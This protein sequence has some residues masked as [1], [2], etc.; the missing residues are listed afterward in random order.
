MWRRKV[1]LWIYL[2]D[3]TPL[4]PQCTNNGP[5]RAAQTAQIRQTLDKLPQVVNVTYR[6]QAQNLAQFKK[7]FAYDPIFVASVRPG[8]IPAS[9]QAKLRNAQAD[10]GPGKGG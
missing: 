8:D 1:E 7:E 10:A 4:S 6:T 2:G 5:A 3:N 9:F